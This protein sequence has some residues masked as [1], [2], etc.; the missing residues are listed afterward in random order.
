ME[1]VKMNVEVEEME[2]QKK[3]YDVAELAAGCAVIAAT[4]LIGYKIG[5]F[6]GWNKAWKQCGAG[7][8]AIW[9]IDPELK[10]R[11]NK[12]IIDLQGRC[13]K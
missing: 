7:L 4:G 8:N 13:G 5:H 9:L 12:A 10:E 11:M 6:R 3:P 1:N 2:E